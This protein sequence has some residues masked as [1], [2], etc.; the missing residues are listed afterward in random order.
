MKSLNIFIASVSIFLALLLISCESDDAPDFD[1]NENFLTYHVL[2]NSDLNT[3]TITAEFRKL[4]PLGSNLELDSDE[5]ITF[6]GDELVFDPNSISY[7]K[8]YNGLVSEGDFVYSSS[9]GRIYMSTLVEYQSIDFPSTFSS[10]SKSQGATIEWVG[11]NLGQYES[12]LVVIG[13]YEEGEEIGSFHNELGSSSVEVDGVILE[14]LALG[15]QPAYI[16]RNRVVF[17]TNESGEA[18]IVGGRIVAEY[19]SSTIQV[20]VVD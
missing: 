14:V 16:Q 6:E 13:D 18:T 2:Y 4:D 11:N 9:E 7:S 5:S 20:E 1:T 8:T 12:L 17:L 19:R 10:I 3:T 15:T